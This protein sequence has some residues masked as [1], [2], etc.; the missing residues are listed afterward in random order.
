[1][2]LSLLEQVFLHEAREQGHQAAQ[3]CAD[4]AERQGFDTE[5]ARRFILSWLARHGDMS[6]E[7]LTDAAKEHG[8]RPH[9]D[10]AFGAVFGPLSRRGLIRCVGF[11]ERERG[12][13]TAGG[14]IWRLVR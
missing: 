3:A 9:D 6:G 1:M 13:G 14:R 5:G 4:K 12:H 7:A 8:F 2:Q 10:R 11:C